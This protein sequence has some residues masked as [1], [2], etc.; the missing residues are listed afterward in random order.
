MRLPR[1]RRGGPVLAVLAVLA[2]LTGSTL[3]PT[4]ASATTA[5]AATPHAGSPRAAAPRAVAQ[6]G[7]GEIAV[8]VLDLNPT[9]PRYT[10]DPQPLTVT[11]SLHNQTAGT[12]YQLRVDG[13][14]EA[15]ITS[16][17]SSR[18]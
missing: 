2:F 16:R 17:A 11:L 18:R 7:S 4:A 5:Q 10:T 6:P 15:P 3:F 8:Q 1:S 12:L 9:T 14:R 13:A